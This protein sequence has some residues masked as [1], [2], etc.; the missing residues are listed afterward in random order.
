MSTFTQFFPRGNSGGNVN[1]IGGGTTPVE[2]IGMSGGGGGG[3]T[4]FYPGCT[5][6]AGVEAAALGGEGGMGA[7]FVANNYYITPGVQYPITIGSGG[8][9]GDP[10]TAGGAD[11]GNAY[12]GCN[13][14]ATI[15][16]NPQ[17]TLC[18]CGGGG[19]GGAGHVG[20][21]N[22]ER[23]CG[24]DGGT[25]GAGGGGTTVGGPLNGPFPGCQAYGCGGRGAYYE[26]QL[27][28][29][30]HCSIDIFATHPDN[31]DV[32]FCKLTK[33]ENIVTQ[34]AETLKTPWGF[35]GGFDA[36]H[37]GQTYH[38]LTTPAQCKCCVNTCGGGAMSN[39]AVNVGVCHCQPGSSNLSPGNIV[40][41]TI[42]SRMANV[43]DRYFNL[44]W[45]STGRI[46]LGSPTSS[47]AT[48]GA[49]GP[50]GGF[51]GQPGVLFI[52]YPDQYPAATNVTNGTDC[53]PVTPGYRSYR[54]S[55]SGS[56]TL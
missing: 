3:G 43:D 29:C 45:F 10:A 37:S 54:F 19:G 36:Y 33:V 52:R 5:Q 53:S 9:A 41:N 23:R 26:K 6:G 14:G 47:I 18:V 4:A 56:I 27:T 49:G 25:G 17:L 40:V 30:H 31:T 13:G 48:G 39:T 7:I 44:N 50:S 20:A 21:A 34:R 35:M 38:G 1:N 24:V 51:A 55:S 22:A 42:Q 15:F 32:S 12:Q 46:C 2:I 28:I 11:P 8:D 16:G